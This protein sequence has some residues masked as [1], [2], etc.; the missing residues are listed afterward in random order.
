MKGKKTMCHANGWQKRAGVSRS[1]SSKMDFKTNM[2]IRDK[3]RNDSEV[4]PR[5][6]IYKYSPIQHRAPKYMKQIMTDLK[7]EIHS[8][9]AIV[10]DF[11]TPITSMDRSP[12]QSI[13]KHQPWMKCKNR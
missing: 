13:R 12:R 1:V 4:N 8:Y 11:N 2:V 3:V 7:V 6:Y 5:R 9:A 10:G